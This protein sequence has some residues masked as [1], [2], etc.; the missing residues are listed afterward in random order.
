LKNAAQASV[1]ASETIQAST[2]IRYIHPDGTEQ[3][4]SYGELWATANRY[5]V[6]LKQHNLQPHDLVVLHFSHSPDFITAFW[7]CLL[8]GFVPVPIAPL[9][10]YTLDSAKAA[11]LVQALQLIG[12]P[13]ILTEQRLQPL[14]QDFLHVA[15]VPASVVAANQLQIRTDKQPPPHVYAPD[16]LALIILTSG[17]TGTPKG[18]QLSVCNLLV[19]A[20]G[21]AHVNGLSKESISLNWM[22]LEH[23]ATLVMFHFTQVFVGCQQIHAAHELVLQ[24]PLKWLDLIDRHRVTATWAPNFAYGLVNEHA[25]V[26]QQRQWDLSSLRWMGNGAEA[27]VGK[28]TRQFLQILIPHG[29]NPRAVSPGYGMSETCSGILHSHN[30]SLDSSSDDVPFVSVGTPIPGVSVRI[31][32]S[33]NQVVEAGVIGHL[34]VKGLTVTSGYYQRPD[35]NGEMFTPDGWFNTGDLAVMHQGAIAITGRQKEMIVINGVNY[36]SHDIESAVDELDGVELSFTAACGVRQPDD[37]SDRLAI[38]FHPTHADPDSLTALLRLMRQRLLSVIGINPDYL[39]PV[40]AAAI[41]KTTIGKIQ[42]RQLSQ[43]FQQGEFDTI[44]QQVQNLLSRQSHHHRP[45]NELERQI[46]QIW[47]DILHLDSVGTQDNFFELGGNSLRLMQVLHRL[48]TILQRSIPAVDLFQYPTIQALAQHLSQAAATPPQLPLSLKRDRHLLSTSSPDVAVIGMAGRFPGAKNLSEF[49]QNLC[50]G[51]ESISVFSDDELLTS[52]VAPDL[53]RHP[54]YV[55]ASPILDD[56]EHFDAEFFGYSPKEAELIDPQQRLLLECAWESLEDAGYDPL[57]YPGAIALY[58]GASM[59]T[60]LLNHVYPNRGRL[61][62][63]DP[64]DVLTLSSMGGFQMT[65]AN[66]KDYLT[67]RVS[68]KLNLRGASVNVQTAC[69]TSLVA[70]HMAAQSVINGE[71]DMALA[72]GVSVHTP[73]KVGHLFQ[74]GMILTPDGHCRA[75]DAKAQGTLFGSGVGLVVLKRLDEAIADRDQVYAVIKGSAVGND[76]SMKVGYFAPRADG[77]AAVAADAIARASIDADSLTY[78]E[79]HGTGTPLGDPIEIAGLTQALRATTSQ[80]QFCAI[81]SVKTNVGHLNIASGVVGFIKTVLALHHQKI[82]PSLHFETPNPQIDFSQSPFFVNTR[83]TDWQTSGHPRR[84]GVNSLGIGGTNVHVILEEAP[85]QTVQHSDAGAPP[86]SDRPQILVLSARSET[87]L[88]QQAD[89]Y[90]DWLSQHPS[91]SLADLC[92]T[93]SVGR[94]HFQQRLALVAD[95]AE[96]MQIQLRAYAQDQEAIALVTGQAADHPNSGIAILFTGQGSQ[97]RGM[98][99]TLYH[100]QPVFRDALDRCDAI[101]QNLLSCSLLDVISAADDRLAQTQYTQPALFALEY[102]LVQLWQSWGIE[103]A[104][105]MGHSVGEYVAACVAGVFSLEDGLTLIAAR[106][107]L[108]QALPPGGMVAVLADRPTVLAA[109]APHPDVAIAALNGQKNIVISGPSD[110]L[111]QAVHTLSEQGI[112][113]TPLQVSHAFHSLMMQP[114]L[115]EFGQI[116]RQI[117]YAPPR[118]DLISN[119]TGELADEAIATP[120]YWCRH[121]HQPVQFAAGLETLENLGY[122]IFLECGAKPVLLGMAKQKAEGRR[123]KAEGEKQKA[124]GRRQKQH[125]S[126]SSYRDVPSSSRPLFLPSLHPDRPN[127]QTLLLS[128]GQLYVRGVPIRWEAVYTGQTCHRISL[129][130]YPFQRQRYWLDVAH[131]GGDVL[132]GGHSGAMSL[133]GLGKHPLLG[134]RLPSALKQRVFISEL[135]AQSPAYLADHRVQDQIILPGTA[136]L[137]MALAAGIQTLKRSELRLTQV[138]MQEAMRFT[139]SASRAVQVILSPEGEGA[140]FEIYSAIATDDD[141]DETDWTLHCSGNLAPAIPPALEPVDL[142]QLQQAYTQRRSPQQH[143]THC[144]ARGISYGSS[145]Q[146]IEA[147]WVGDRA[148]LGLIQT[149]PQIAAAISAYQLHPTILDACLQ[150]IFAAL[151]D[152]A[153]ANLYLPVSLDCFR[154]DRP[155]PPRV[156]SHVKLRPSKPAQPALITADVWLYDNQ[157][158]LIAHA[159]GLSAQRV[160]QFSFALT[161]Q[162]WHD[163]LYT[164]EWRP[165][166]RIQPSQP[167]EPG[168]WLIVAEN[169][170]FVQSLGDRLQSQQH[171]YTVISPNQVMAHDPQASTFISRVRQAMQQI[172]NPLRGVLYCCRCVPNFDADADFDE[173]DDQSI[174]SEGQG[175]VGLGEGK[176]L[177][178]PTHTDDMQSVT[179]HHLHPLLHLVQTLLTAPLLNDP[180]PLYL[181]THSPHSL[182]PLTPSLPHSPLWGF[183]NSLTLEH[184]HLLCKRIDLDA[185]PGNPAIAALIDELTAPDLETQVAIR[186]GVRYVARLVPLQISSQ[187]HCSS[188]CQQNRQLQIVQR[189]ILDAL[190]WMPASR[191]VPN[192]NEVEIRVRTTGLNFRDVLNALNLYPGEAGA[193]GLECA[194]EIVALGSQ[195]QDLQIGD[196]VMAIAPASFSRYV[197]VDAHLV[198]PIPDSLSLVAAATIPTAFLTAYYALCV[199]GQIKR[200]DRVLIHAAAGGVGQAAVQI[201]QAVGADIFATASPPKWEFLQSLGIQ[202]IMNS[203]TLDFA[204][205]I[206]DRTHGVGV[207]LVLNSLSGDFIPHSLDVLNPYGRFLE[208]GKAQIW[209]PDQVAQHRPDIAYSVIDLVQLTQQQP[210]LIQTLLRQLMPQFSPDADRPLRPLPYQVFSDNEAIAA[211]RHMQQ[212]KHIGKIIIRQDWEPGI[213]EQNAP[214]E[215]N[216]QVS[217]PSSFKHEAQSLVSNDLAISH[218]APVLSDQALRLSDQAQSPSS[219]APVLPDEALRL[220]DEALRLSDEAPILSDEVPI[221]SDEVPLLASETLILANEAPILSDKAPNPSDEASSI[222]PDG[223]YLITGGLGS[224][225]LQVA[226]WL[227]QQG[228]K[229][230]LLIGRSQPTDGAIA[231]IHQLRQAGVTIHHAQA[232]VSQLEDIERVLRPYLEGEKQK[233]EGRRQKVERESWQPLEQHDTANLLSSSSTLRPPSSVP[234]IVGVFHLAGLL[235]DGIIQQQTWERFERVMAPKIQGAWH[236]H[237]LTQHLP[238][239]H[240]VLFSS[241]ASLIGSAGQANYAAAN[242]FLDALAHHRQA[243][244]LPGLSINWSAWSQVGMAVHSQATENLQRQGISPIDPQ[245]GLDILNHILSQDVAQVGVLPIDW[246]QWTQQHPQSPFLADL[247]TQPTQFPESAAPT[248]LHQL[249]NLPDEAQTS[250]LAAH[251]RTQLAHVLGL[252]PDSLTEPDVGFS[253]LGLDSL[254]SVELRNRLQTTLG[255]S[256]PATLLYD[257]PTLAD[258]TRYLH[259]VLIPATQSFS[260]FSEPITPESDAQDLDQLSDADAEALLLDELNRLN[261]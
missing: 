141:L 131:R 160:T 27:V 134:R 196:V 14:V 31:T 125:G 105:V 9:P 246:L 61:D 188:E 133:R 12:H 33:D 22:P 195:V 154:Q 259:S 24:D 28:T 233:A 23:V 118:I 189:G 209:N 10:H 120:D 89:C 67:T 158:V 99:Q 94:S 39:I 140:S 51:I 245:I 8:G 1:G 202:H 174:L 123:Q 49:W 177:F 62:P 107:R 16:D 145:F 197:T 186:N 85:S 229:H 242:A 124:E 253:E 243:A 184:P 130:T 159:A 68:Y 97:Y 103:P 112:K 79:A 256:L 30:F 222:R 223:T 108:M 241:A 13:L 75:F 17:S 100:S 224:L 80:T 248:L 236:L 77:Q 35:L 34:Q 113:T 207:D 137:E 114:M 93:A 56:V 126:P 127:W 6:G 50:N 169:G 244:G 226:Q 144:E 252:T 250:H 15:Q 257:Y 121:I 214:T 261:Y 178:A 152:S 96:Q 115:A 20:Y 201:A 213:H 235:D 138:V 82:P 211:F 52:G 232:D 208:I 60:Y 38:F 187:P 166:S 132:R 149:P 47:Q 53:L 21:M 225:G 204:Q 91:V 110:S 180:P 183:A 98:G 260:D 143:Y 116:A 64:L 247:P 69:S 148:A 220:S 175:L 227:V 48:Q 190:A 58:A 86:M 142:K 72:G 37:D 26:I 185:T 102:A 198:I 135:A 87:A 255:R 109:I 162:P 5:F 217:L 219:E 171:T 2:G 168:H 55:K 36:Y 57:C 199:V 139:P 157:G 164:V 163:W 76:G 194:G 147:L 74:D 221:L 66:D 181:I 258:L 95:T 104:I 179:R 156:W 165:Y 230:L 170:E 146:G 84:A 151:P 45:R 206:R 81:G 3:F 65:V 161:S 18:V 218:Q 172:P 249:A 182:H 111:A 191:R 101:L 238:L 25:D 78:I 88:R 240:F 43:R 106:G 173:S 212:A 70:I 129:P 90:A 251:I 40:E 205:E 155:L 73:Q 119:V 92:F 200:G 210:H 11:S 150:V 54:R 216:L 42:R 167:A 203:R 4:Q 29:L 176:Q 83:L 237:R 128:L 192:P 122:E 153:P 46:A 41:P 193:L 136:Y 234:P 44:L 7:G 59:N 254:T 19:S 215:Q 231:T 32:D 63:N 239:D 117:T 228:A 71:C